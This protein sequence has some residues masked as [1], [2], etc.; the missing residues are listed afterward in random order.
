MNWPLI[1][2]SEIKWPDA[3]LK[4]KLAFLRAISA[5]PSQIGA[6]APSGPAL[7]RLITSEI[8][9]HSGP[10]IELGPGTGVFT[11]A[12]LDQGVREQ[13]LTLI[14]CCPDFAQLLEQRFPA[15]RVLQMDAGRLHRQGLFPQ[16]SIGAVVSGLPLLNMSPAKVLTLLRGAFRCMHSGGAFY[17][18][19]YGPLCPVPKT[20][21]DRLNLQSTC[22]GRAF[23]NIPPAAVYRITRRSPRE[24]RNSR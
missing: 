10:I 6:I 24:P 11:Q 9:S 20:C 14:E 12:L 5:D 1:N 2:W 17:Q 15:A 21:L 23:V 8:G 13:D 3:N 7:A 22:L 18:F 19:T 4:D 16:E